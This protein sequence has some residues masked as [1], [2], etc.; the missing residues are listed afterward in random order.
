MSRQERVEFK[1]VDGLTLRGCLYAAEKKGPAIIMTPG[2]N[3]TKEMFIAEIAE[4]FQRAGFTI[5]TYDPRSIGESDGV[6]KN[7]I[8]PV[9]NAEDYH[10]AL[11]FMK[12]NPLV[13]ASRIAFWGFSFSAMVALTAAALDKRVKAVIAVAPLSIFDFPA[14]K[15]PRVLAKAMK[16]RES[17]LSGNEAFYI[18]MITEQGENPAGFGAGVD[19]E[20]FNLLAGAKTLVPNFKLPTTL[21]SYYNIAAWQPLGLMKYVSPTPVLVITPEDDAISPAAEQKRLIFDRFEEPKKHIVVSDKGH[22]D[23]LSGANFESVLDQQIEF[24]LSAMG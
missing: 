16:D 23:L 9:R 8:D 3:F 11:T 10:D 1:T 24:L 2:F 21:K 4:Y 6:P 17:Q 18:P 12:S 20:G 22:M 7:E 13:D 15:W 19:K 5:L 14:D